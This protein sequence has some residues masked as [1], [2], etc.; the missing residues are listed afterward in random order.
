[1][2]ENQQ[3]AEVVCPPDVDISADSEDPDDPIR[4]VD[5][6]NVAGSLEVHYLLSEACENTEQPDTLP[7]RTLEVSKRKSSNKRHL[8]DHPSAWSK[9]TPLYTKLSVEGSQAGIVLKV[10]TERL[11]PLS[12]I[13]EFE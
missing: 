1:V 8:P 9:T 5:V 2:S 4:N 3:R 11:L 10:L 6:R 12:H 7:T 13:K